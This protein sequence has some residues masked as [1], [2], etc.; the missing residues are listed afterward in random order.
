MWKNIIFGNF[1][2]H[3]YEDAFTIFPLGVL[4]F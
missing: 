4:K 1:Y 2:I 3:N